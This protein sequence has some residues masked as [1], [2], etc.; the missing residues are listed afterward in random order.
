MSNANL[1]TD[2]LTGL[3]RPI[4]SER[5]QARREA[6]ATGH[7]RGLTI[8]SGLACVL[9]SSR[10]TWKSCVHP[11]ARGDATF[12]SS[13]SVVKYFIPRG[14]AAALLARA[15]GMAVEASE[16]RSVV[17]F[18]ESSFALMFPFHTRSVGLGASHIKRASELR[19]RRR[20][21][22]C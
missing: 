19:S 12:R 10:R 21:V 14:A 16:A 20:Y 13:Y 15:D 4:A 11:R 8:C 6:A 18:S 5:A 7:S 17:L 22:R 3:I 2:R 1:P 9:S